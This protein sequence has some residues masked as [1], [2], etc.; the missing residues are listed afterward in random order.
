LNNTAQ[1]YKRKG[2]FGIKSDKSTHNNLRF[3]FVKFDKI[4][5]AYKRIRKPSGKF[6]PQKIFIAQKTF[7]LQTVYV[8][9]C[10]AG[11]VYDKINGFF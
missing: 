11:F 9:F 6:F 8:R 10:F 5:T 7:G 1:G 3:Q 4:V 2:G